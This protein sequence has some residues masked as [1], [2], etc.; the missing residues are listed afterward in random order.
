MPDKRVTV[1]TPVYNDWESFQLLIETLDKLSSENQ[2]TLSITI[3][4]DGS[5][6]EIPKILKEQ[7]LYQHVHSLKVLDLECNVGHQKAIAI[8]LASISQEEESD[9]I[10]VMDSDGEDDPKYISEMLSV[11]SKNPQSVVL[12]KRVQRSEGAVFQIFYFIY[13]YLFRLL[14]GMGISFGN[15]CAVSPAAAKRLASSS[16]LV[17]SFPATILRSKIP[18]ITVDTKRA[19]RLSGSSQMNFVGLILHGLQAISVFS[20]IVLIRLFLMVFGTGLTAIFAVLIIRFSTDWVV[21]GWTSN[22]VGFIAMYMFITLLGL[23]IGGI[24]TLQSRKN[25]Q[26]IPIQHWKLYLRKITVMFDKK[27]I[28]ES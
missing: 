15:F 13:K 18:F 22:M 2:W 20:D 12:A 27:K 4:N 24:V 10:V 3:I 5:I 1:L 7:N 11:F 17:N 9:I 14:T 19:E 26:F 21:P 23:I 6:Q 16:D 8:G 28:C 25:F